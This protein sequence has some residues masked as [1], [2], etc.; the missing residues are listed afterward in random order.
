MDDT[1]MSADLVNENVDNNSRNGNNPFFHMGKNTPMREAP[2][3][4]ENISAL[5]DQKLAPTSAVM[6]NL[7][8]ALRDG[9]DVLTRSI[10]ML[11]MMLERPNVTFANLE[12]VERVN[13][14]V[15][16][17]SRR[18]PYY[19]NLDAATKHTWGNNVT[20]NLVF[21]EFLSNEYRRSFVE[22]HF[23]LCKLIDQEEYIGGLLARGLAEKKCPYPPVGALLLISDSENQ[24]LNYIKS[25]YDYSNNKILALLQ[26]EYRLRN[27][28]APR[29]KMNVV[30]PFSRARI[31]F[32]L[33]TRPS[34]DTI[35]TGYVF[36]TIK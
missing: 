2:L 25:K 5:L 33:L 28:T 34:N 35:T 8:F 31:D 36:V 32:Y 27:L 29:S 18:S 1:A 17:Y 23:P 20:I 16:R 13:L 14:T 15:V 10:T 24:L 21:Y 30:W 26:E 19:I 12:Y 9:V 3:A 7:R 11:E 22:F 6:P 4:I